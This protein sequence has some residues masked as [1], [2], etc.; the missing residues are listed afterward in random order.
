MEITKSLFE[1][2]IGELFHL[3][4][5]IEHPISLTLTEVSTPDERIVQQA[6]GMDI[7]EP[8]SLLFSGPLEPFL[9]QHM[10]TL[11]HDELG[12]V[13]MFLVP[14]NQV[15]NNYFYEAVFG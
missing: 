4:D 2:R 3:Y 5:V 8:F 10:Y 13:E 14:V 11:Q 12:M 9:Q 15:E 7:R 1:G 6:R